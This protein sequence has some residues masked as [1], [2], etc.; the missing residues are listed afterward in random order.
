[1]YYVYEWF[2]TDTNEIFY[3]GK[4]V[5]NRYKVRKRNKSFNEYLKTHSCESR[6]VK[7]FESEKEAFEYEY[8]YINLLKSKGQ[9]YC[10]L[11]CGGAGGSGEYWTEELRKEYSIHNVMKSEE[12]R[13]RMSVNNPMKNKD[14]AEKAN[15]KKRK[16]V[17]I[18]GVEY[19][20]VKEATQKLNT[21]SDC[22]QYWCK[23]GKNKMGQICYYKGETPIEYDNK[24][25]NK[26]GCK[27]IIYKDKEYESPIDI[28]KELGISKYI[29]YN[30]ARNGFDEYGNVCRYVDDNRHLE[31]KRRKGQN[32][33]IIVNSK[34]YQSI[35]EAAR[36]LNVSSQYLGEILRG[37]YKSNKYICEYD[38]QQPSQTKSDN[39][40][41]EGST[42][43][44]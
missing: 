42:T 15:G 37:K 20:S 23:R 44:G 38:N 7:Y 35:S 1:M 31:F 27:S 21:S 25:Y 28:S 34:H 22:I 33:H 18:D 17:I 6:I 32:H 8:Y 19:S 5:N 2:D 41:L 29:I 10:N 4:G 30:W 16:P 43:N 9:C 40:S 13:K 3:V 24:R 26:G 39:S 12:Q 14:I 36:E 11:H